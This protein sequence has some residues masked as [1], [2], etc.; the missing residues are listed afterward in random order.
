MK[1]IGF[2]Q[3]DVLFAPIDAIPPGCVPIEPENGRLI[4]ARG[5]ASGHHHSFAHDRGAT[6]FRDDSWSGGSNLKLEVV[7]AVPL[8]H[9]EHSALIGVPHAYQGIRQRTYVGG[10]VKSVVD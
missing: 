2:R 7:K 10:V 4:A 8:E 1:K 9:Q 5:E 6:L 3:G